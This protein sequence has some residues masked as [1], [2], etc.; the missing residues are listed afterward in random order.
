MMP[1]GY[2]SAK[3][4][5]TPIFS[6]IEKTSLGEEK[7]EQPLNCHVLIVSL[8]M[9]SGVAAVSNCYQKSISAPPRGALRSIFGPALTGLRR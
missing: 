5:S 1:I 3:A 6:G 4:A 7:R 2:F 8:R 9:P